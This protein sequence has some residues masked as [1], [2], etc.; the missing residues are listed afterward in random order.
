MKPWDFGPAAR[1]PPP[2]EEKRKSAPR[3]AARTVKPRIAPHAFERDPTMPVDFDGTRW[4]RCGLPGEAGDAR[5]PLD[6]PP[7]IARVFPP[8][9][10]GAREIDDRILGEGGDAA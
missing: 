1:P 2:G 10:P 7:L 8:P 6:A 4:C 9:P 5:H 3:K